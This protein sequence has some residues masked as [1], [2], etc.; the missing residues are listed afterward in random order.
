MA[1]R[2]PVISSN[3]GGIP[4]VNIQGYSGY[5][6]NVGDVEDMAANALSILSS[7]E[8]LNLFKDNALKRAREFSLKKILPLYESLYENVVSLSKSTVSSNI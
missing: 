3:T 8:N 4:E 1:V 2:V 7:P 5:L 6:S